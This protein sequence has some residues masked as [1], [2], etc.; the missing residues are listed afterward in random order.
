MDN[1][2]QAKLMFTDNLKLRT[3]SVAKTAAEH[4][5]AVDRDARFPA[6]AFASA[7]AQQLLGV[8][9][10]V[11]LGGEGAGLADVVDQ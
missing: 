4:A 7:R 1:I 6:E 2:T 11:D 5:D 9:V 10:P 8:M 3:E